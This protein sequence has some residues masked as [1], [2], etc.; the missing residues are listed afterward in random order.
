MFLKQPKNTLFSKNF[1]ILYGKFRTNLSS[2]LEY[3]F[4]HILKA[5]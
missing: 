4:Q 3:H 1:Y 5:S 2:T